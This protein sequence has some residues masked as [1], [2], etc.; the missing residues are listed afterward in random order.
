VE[1]GNKG[2]LLMK[3]SK[4]ISGLEADAADPQADKQKFEAALAS[5]YEAAYV[6]SLKKDSKIS[7]NTQLMNAANQ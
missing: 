7:V 2:Y 5:E 1:D 3:V 6:E 4:V